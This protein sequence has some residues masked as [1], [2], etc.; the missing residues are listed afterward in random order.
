MSILAN[1]FYFLW[2]ITAPRPSV[3][4]FW[5]QFVKFCQKSSGQTVK[6]RLCGCGLRRM[7][8]KILCSAHIRP[9]RYHFF[10]PMIYHHTWYHDITKC[11]ELGG[12]VCILCHASDNDGW[13][14]GWSHLPVLGLFLLASTDQDADFL[15]GYRDWKCFHPWL[16]LLWTVRWSWLALL[17]HFESKMFPNRSDGFSLSSFSSISGLVSSLLALA[18]SIDTGLSLIA[19]PATCISNS[20]IKSS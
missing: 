1:C 19:R 18:G 4:N 5:G 16:P 7:L 9:S 11:R 14:A 10:H 8:F 20:S 15:N 12:S 13:P 3:L 6:K 2:K 17:I